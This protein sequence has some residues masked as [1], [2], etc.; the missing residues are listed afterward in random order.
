MGK[1]YVCDRCGELF[2]QRDYDD[3]VPVVLENDQEIHT[4]FG[5]SQIY[6]SLCPKCRI[7]FQKWW[8]S[9]AAY[10]TTDGIH[11]CNIYE[12]PEEDNDE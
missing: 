6:V 2:K 3:A 12:V 1:A 11:K 5:N 7:G 4:S 10:K 8:D 9:G